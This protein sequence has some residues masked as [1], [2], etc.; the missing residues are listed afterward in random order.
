MSYHP[1]PNR[2]ATL[3][4]WTRPNAQKDWEDR[5]QRNPKSAVFDLLI[6]CDNK[7]EAHLFL[8][9]EY[10]AEL[11]VVFPNGNKIVRFMDGRF[12]TVTDRPDTI[13]GALP[14]FERWNWYGKFNNAPDL[15]ILREKRQVDEIL[16]ITYN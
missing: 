12:V 15:A 13:V 7:E 3:V 4:N 14:T 6:V 10:G 2:K 5:C 16:K 11:A 8:E 1:F 9:E